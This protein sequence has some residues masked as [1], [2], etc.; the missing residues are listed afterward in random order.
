MKIQYRFA[1]TLLLGGYCSALFAQD[2]VEPVVVTATRYAFHASDAPYASEVHGHDEITHSGA[3]TLYE[4]LGQYTSL[5]VMPSYGNPFAQKLDMRGYGI[6]DGYQNIVVTLDG[7][8]LNNIDM[9]PQ[10]LSAIPLASIDRIEITK[11]SG[12]VMY[13]DGATAGAIHIYTRDIS[14]A[15]VAASSGNHGVATT[16]VSA[17]LNNDRAALTV[18]SENYRQDGFSDADTSG[19]RDEASSN[20]THAML[21]VYPS[22]SIELR[23][24]K[25]LS[26]IDTYYRGSLTQTQFDADPQQ[27]GGKTYTHQKFNADNTTLGLSADLSD[28]VKLTLDSYAEDKVSEYPAWSYK[29][30]YDYR[31]NDAALHYQR[32][33]LALT[34][35]LQSFDGQRTGSDN[36]TGKESSGYYV[37][38][39]YQAGSTTYSA[40]GRGEK[41]RYRYTPTSG[42]ALSADHNLAAYDVGF[43]HRID[44]HLSLFANYNYAYQAPDIDRFF[45]YDAFYNIVFNGFIA[46]AQS[47]T[48]NLGVNRD[49][50]TDRMQVTLF[51]TALTNEIYYYKTGPYSG[52]NTN[53][54]RS[55]K[56]GLELQE[57][58][59]FSDRLSASL[60]YGYTRAIIDTEDSGGGAYNGKDLP[61]VPRH[62][63]T[64]GVNYSPTASS[65]LALSHTY[66]SDAY[67]AEDFA[68]TFT[69]KQAAYNSTDLT[70]T[71]RA[72]KVELYAK[73]ENLLG[74]HNGQWIRD[75][76]IY[77]VNFTTNWRLGIRAGF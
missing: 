45:T 23:A 28:S 9:V 63:V 59:R 29:F 55:H 16:S 43:N 13:G 37:Q 25:D 46:P 3:A 7:R 2:A 20:N 51:Y 76:V 66:R 61:G 60:L 33:A 50:D 12:S 14:G 74:Q 62:T 64:L 71:Y 49:S 15:Q 36:R 31:S 26:W 69:Q 54:D 75:D 21:R 1:A 6:G 68:N 30:N 5:T 72:D 65:T 57:H 41:F 8:R 19:Q 39:H 44:P 42:S 52:S 38:G 77:P 48:L 11:G 27:N 56:Y 4:F 17:G 34:A 73:V 10:L 67:A 22:D 58:H 32:D 70:Y 47:R 40:G 35:G 18:T 24:G 53:I